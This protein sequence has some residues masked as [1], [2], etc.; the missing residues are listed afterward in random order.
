MDFHYLFLNFTQELVIKGR[1]HGR[2]LPPV[3]VF[4]SPVDRLEIIIFKILHPSMSRFLSHL[5]KPEVAAEFIS[6][7]DSFFV[8]GTLY[9]MHWNGDVAD[10]CPNRNRK[11]ARRSA[12][13]QSRPGCTCA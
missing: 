1:S 11:S 9:M 8:R 10:Q 3:D 5:L 2:A 7:C 12:A 4:S 6:L 13:V